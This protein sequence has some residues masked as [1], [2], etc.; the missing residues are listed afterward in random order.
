[1]KHIIVVFPSSVDSRIT[2]ETFSKQTFIM[3]KKP[4]ISGDRLASVQSPSH[5]LS[6][7]LTAVETNMLMNYCGR[8]CSPK[9]KD[10]F[11]SLTLSA[12]FHGVHDSPPQFSCVKRPH[13]FLTHCNKEHFKILSQAIFPSMK[14]LQILTRNI[15]SSHVQLAKGHFKEAAHQGALTKN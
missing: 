14:G 2:S 15:F 7:S 3:K 1:M 13:L 9:S 11:P 5:W 8:V 10:P 6:G 4:C 12:R